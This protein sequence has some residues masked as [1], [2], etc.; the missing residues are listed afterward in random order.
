MTYGLAW[1]R[2]HTPCAAT[3][4]LTLPDAK[5]ALRVVVPFGLHPLQNG[6]A[7]LGPVGH[8]AAGLQVADVRLLAVPIEDADVG[9]DVAA[10]DG[11]LNAPHLDGA[12]EVPVLVHG[13]DGGGGDG[14]QVDALQR[15]DPTRDGGGVNPLLLHDLLETFKQAIVPVK[16]HQDRARG[17]LGHEVLH[18]QPPFIWYADMLPEAPASQAN[19]LNPGHPLSAPAVRPDTK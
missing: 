16:H 5:I 4:R 17:R 10:D 8:D 7:D 3:Q 15:P 1:T 11:A 12:G 6:Q 13:L 2:H 19:L 9:V 18:G 14:V